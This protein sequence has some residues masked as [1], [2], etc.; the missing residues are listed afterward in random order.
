MLHLVIAD[1]R[2]SLR[3]WIGALVVLI[4]V[5]ISAM[6]VTG[7][8]MVSITNTPLFLME[9]ATRPPFRAADGSP[10]DPQLVSLLGAAGSSAT[11]MAFIVISFVGSLTVR[12]VVNSIVYQRRRV[13]ALWQLAGMT[14]RQLLRVLRAQI[15]LLSVAAFIVAT[16]VAILLTPAVLD[17]MRSAQLLYTPPMSTAGVYPGYAL[18]A[19]AIA[20]VC[21]LAVRGVGRELR[22]IS[23]LEAIRSEGVR[24]L[25]MDR[26]RWTGMIVFGVLAACAIAAAFTSADPSGAAMLALLGGV[27][28]IAAVNTG[29]PITIIGLVRFWTG[30][31]PEHVSASW[32][33]ARKTLIASTARTVAASGSIATAVFLFTSLFASNSG[34]A[35]QLAGFILLVGFPLGVSVTGSVV[36][37]FMAGQQ[38]EREIHLA[39]LA[40]ATPAQ[41]RRQALFEGVIVVG[42]GGGIGL[43]FSTLLDAALATQGA[44]DFAPPWR[45]F[46]IILSV[47]LLLNVIAT[48]VPTMLAHAARDRIATPE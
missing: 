44:A 46:G 14:D 21:V 29:G 15:A 40:G 34:S 37:V 47:L 16:P 18:G 27:L 22:T 10:L 4:V 17:I 24:E 19:A 2:H 48:I 20:L 7:M 41:Q 9:P 32:F 39:E 33:L 23:P 38:R 30:L 6:S 8:L 11:T 1:L 5:Q 45:D 12:N 28:G 42:T 35:S 31:V 25:P 36:L 13:M 26:R 3:I 43:F